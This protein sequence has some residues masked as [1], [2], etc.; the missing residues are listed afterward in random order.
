MNFNTFIIFVAQYYLFIAI[1]CASVYFFQQPKGKRRKIFVFAILSFPLIY[2]IA[3]IAAHFYFDPRP[4]TITHSTPLIA[5]DPDNG[6]PSDHVLL[7]SAVAMLFSFFNRKLGVFLWISA[8]AVGVA[9]IYAGVHHPFDVAGS[10]V[11]SSIVS[12]IV[13][14]GL[15]RLNYLSYGT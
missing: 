10:I 5:H 4:F 8:L 7:L 6:F 14:A 1:L 12:I 9:R 2:V 3:N 13:Y 15:K 11:I